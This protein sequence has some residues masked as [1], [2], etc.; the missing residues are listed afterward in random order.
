MGELNGYLAEC[1]ALVGEEIRRVVPSDSPDTGGLY[2]MVL[3]YP[4][5]EAKGLRP[6]LCIATSRMLGASLDEALPTAAALELYHN[7]FLVHDDVEDGSILR[8]GRPTLQ[9]MVGVPTAVNVGDGMLAL[10]MRPLL[11]NTRHLGVRR[12]LKVL[13]ELVT[14]A[15]LSAEGQA[16]ELSWVRHP[17]RRVRERDYLRMVYRKTA[18]YS[19][20]TPVRCGVFIA[21]AGAHERALLRFAALLGIAFQIQDDAL[22][23][24]E[25]PR[26]GKERAGD[27]WEGKRTLMLIHALE[28]A[29]ETER[30]EASRVLSL[31]RGE[32]TE[33]DV[34]VLL[35]LI[36][37]TGGRA[38][39]L[40]VAARH[41]DRAR[42]VLSGLARALPETSHLRFLYNLSRFVL[43]RAW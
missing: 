36:A 41:A 20:V 23:L 25:S 30:Q 10:A 31:P 28:R 9:A 26:L 5:R 24:D 2:A 17:E 12:A 39:A 11:E 1:R 19:F 6:A 35:D 34:S 21:E 7:A 3:D 33:E 38:Y 40:E 18:R 37:R 13:D 14:M 22:N 4:M 42:V 32:K 27:L 29:T 8:R 15:Q 43:E 16:A